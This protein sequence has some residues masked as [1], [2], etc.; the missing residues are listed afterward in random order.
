M[1]GGSLPPTKNH[2]PDIILP[3]GPRFYRSQGLTHCRVGN[4]T[5]DISSVSENEENGLGD[6]GADGAITHPRIFGLEPP[7]VI[8]INFL[9]S[10]RTYLVSGALWLSFK[11]QS[12][13][14]V[15]TAVFSRL[16]KVVLSA[17]K[18]STAG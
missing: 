9:S 4:T 5:N 17:L 18:L 12:L 6:E 2:T 13:V 7:L 1:G 14:F 16:V 10:K 8:R 3:F 15:Q 11:E